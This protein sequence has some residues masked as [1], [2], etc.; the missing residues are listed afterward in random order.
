MAQV[1]VKVNSRDYTISCDDGQ[2]E[3]LRQL[4]KYLDMQVARLSEEIGQVGDARL[5]LMAGLVI[6]DELSEALQ[7]IETLEERIDAGADQTH[8]RQTA[9]AE[10]RATGA[11]NEA[12]G[13]LELFARRLDDAVAGA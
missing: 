13:R 2:E 1:V 11:L 5:L 9:A 6:S 10:V 8:L 12:A 4:A 7:Q 3:T